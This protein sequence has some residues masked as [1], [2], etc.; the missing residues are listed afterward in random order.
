ME[1]FAPFSGLNFFLLFFAFI[2]FLHLF[3]NNLNNYKFS[4]AQKWV[5][6][7]EEW[8]GLVDSWSK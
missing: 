8:N 7:E 3:K 2:L 6:F 4:S 5:D 1:N